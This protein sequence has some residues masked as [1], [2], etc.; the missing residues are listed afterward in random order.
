MLDHEA[1][2]RLLAE[3]L[4]ASHARHAAAHARLAEGLERLGL[5]L[6]V[7]PEARLPQLNAVVIPE[8][9]EDAAFRGR[10]LEGH[11]IEI[12]A[13]LGPLAGKVWRIGLMGENAR[14]EAV[15]RVLA[16]MAAELAGVT[17]VA[18]Q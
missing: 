12:G 2:E 15:D 18:A 3:G 10:L 14:P 13:G 1:L 5:R 9:M 11:G 16:A 17:A 7:A 4:E 6:L 8:G